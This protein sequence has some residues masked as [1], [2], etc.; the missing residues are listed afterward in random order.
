[1]IDYVIVTVLKDGR[2]REAVLHVPTDEAARKA[3]SQTWTGA[4]DAVDGRLLKV[5]NQKHVSILGGGWRGLENRTPT[6]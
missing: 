4:P 2:K 1:M 5:F 6:A 3:F